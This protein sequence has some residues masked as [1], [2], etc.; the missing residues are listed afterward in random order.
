MVIS[1][2]QPLLE[3]A[4][5]NKYLI[6]TKA[7]SASW[8]LIYQI[9]QNSLSWKSQMEACTPKSTYKSK[10]TKTNMTSMTQ[11]KLRLFAWEVGR[12]FL[13]TFLWKIEAQ[14]FNLTT[15][16]HTQPPPPPEE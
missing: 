6:H 14:T 12:P 10:L 2:G 3:F 1:G 16:P 4:Y 7:E 5:I 15:T 11:T 9:W 8:I 13:D